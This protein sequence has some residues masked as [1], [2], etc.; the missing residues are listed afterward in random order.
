MAVHATRSLE[1]ITVVMAGT[2]IMRAVLDRMKTVT[3]QVAIFVLRT[4]T[5]GLERLPAATAKEGNSLAAQ[6]SG[7]TMP[8]QD[9][10]IV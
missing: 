3:A 1:V 8:F 4:S 10:K 6:L 2:F 9:A 5:A 7:S